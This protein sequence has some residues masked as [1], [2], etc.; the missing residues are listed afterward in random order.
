MCQGT[1]SSWVGRLPSGSDVAMR[2]CTSSEDPDLG[3]NLVHTAVTQIPYII[4]LKLWNK[5]SYPGGSQCLTENVT[6]ASLGCTTLLGYLKNTFKKKKPLFKATNI[7]NAAHA[8][9]PLQP[10]EELQFVW[11]E[12]LSEALAA[13]WT[14]SATSAPDL[15]LKWDPLRLESRPAPKQHHGADSMVFGL[16]NSC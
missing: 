6:A 5:S 15:W 11:C 12:L 14:S 13:L 10:A 7:K 4:P 3:T 16:N 2:W 1:L 8:S 9:R